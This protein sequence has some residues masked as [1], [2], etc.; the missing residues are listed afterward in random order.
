[1]VLSEHERIARGERAQRLL[2]DEMLQE[3]F[4]SLE[5]AYTRMWQMSDAA[6]QATRE[7]AYNLIRNLQH[8]RK[9]LRLVLEDGKTAAHELQLQQRQQRRIA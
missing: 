4:A 7:D 6:E 2:A 8:F 9:H 3:A 5:Q 1:L